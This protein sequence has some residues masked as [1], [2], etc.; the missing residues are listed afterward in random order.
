[1]ELSKNKVKYTRDQAVSDLVK[2]SLCAVLI[3]VCSW[4]SIPAQIPFTLQTLGIFFVLGLLGGKRGTA[5]IGIYILLGA[6][7]IP[8][9]SNFQGGIGALAGATGGYLFGFILTGLAYWGITAAFGRFCHTKRADILLTA[10]AMLAGNIVCY[11][12]GTAHFILLYAR[13]SGGIGIGAA[14]S[15]CVLPFILPDLVKIAIALFLTKAAG[16]S[17]RFGAGHGSHPRKK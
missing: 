12:V 5:S 16:L 9:F 1:M 11:A 14:L 4:I 17:R 13:N 7:G 3:A 8:V 2:I 6:V 10:I 15:L